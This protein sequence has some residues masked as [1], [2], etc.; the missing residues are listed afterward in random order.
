MTV[1]ETETGTD[2]ARDRDGGT[3][4]DSLSYSDKGRPRD[5]DKERWMEVGSQPCRLKPTAAELGQPVA[6]RRWTCERPAL[7]GGVGPG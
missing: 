4:R 5:T 2:R 6:N 7:L 1:T 3:G